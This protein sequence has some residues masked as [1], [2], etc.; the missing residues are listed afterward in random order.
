VARNCF[1][2]VGKGLVELIYFLEHTPMIKERVSFEGKHYLDEAFRQRKGVIA[3]SGHFGNFPL[4]L[5]RCVQEGYQ[6][7]AIMRPARDE[8]IEK[9]FVAQRTK[10]GLNTIYSQPRKECVDTS[11]KVLRNNELLLVLLDQNFG[12][13]GGVFVDFF[14]QK[15]ATATGPV[16]F[17]KRTGAPLVPMFM[18]RQPDDTH[19]I[20]VEPPLILEEGRDEQETIL[21]NTA[22]MTQLIELYIRRYPQEWGWMHRRWK[23]RPTESSVVAPPSTEG[24]INE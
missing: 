24:A 19:K 11:L 23:S 18:I 9:Y 22:K 6:T 16:I 3:V 5:L 12:S 8:N 17:A 21:I 2:N 4:M 1:Q 20:I 14:G 7:N 13:R 15:A 10:L